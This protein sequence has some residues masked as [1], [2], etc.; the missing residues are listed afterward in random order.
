MDTVTFIALLVIVNL[1]IVGYLL[2]SDIEKTKGQLDRLRI[3][4]FDLKKRVSDLE[5]KA[6]ESELR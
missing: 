5:E 1:V 6:N 3:Q 2:R 4:Y